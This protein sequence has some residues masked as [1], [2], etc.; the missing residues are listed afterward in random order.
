MEKSS[1]EHFT[2][3]LTSIVEK[4]EPKSS[5]SAKHNKSWFNEDCKKT[6]KKQDYKK[7]IS[8]NLKSKPNPRESKPIQNKWSKSTQNH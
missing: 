5:K 3:T 4:C 1:L 7:Q 6:P 2:E 8:E